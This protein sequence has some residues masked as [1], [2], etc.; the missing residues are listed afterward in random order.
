MGRLIS[1]RGQLT[2]AS[3][4]PL[5]DRAKDQRFIIWTDPIAIA[6][7]DETRHNGPAPTRPQLI[8]G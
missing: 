5:L 7:V 6:P 4:D 8:V 1:H 2:D 3:G